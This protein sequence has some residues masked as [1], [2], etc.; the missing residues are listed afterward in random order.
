MKNRN[1]KEPI[2]RKS[3]YATDKFRQKLACEERLKELL[4]TYNG[5]FPDLE[6]MNNPKKWDFRAINASRMISD[7]LD[8]RN[9]ARIAAIAKLVDCSKKTLDF[10]VGPGDILAYLINQKY[11]IDYTG[12]D[13]AK[14][15]IDRLT[16]IFPNQ[17]FFC[18]EIKEIE[19]SSFQQIFALE[20][21]EHIEIPSIK[22]I[23]QHIW[24][25]LKD[26]GTLI[27]SVPIYEKLEDFTLCCSKCGH[28]ENSAGHVRAFIPQLV[29]AELEFAGFKIKEYKL[30]F[31]PSENRI[32]N[33]IKTALRPILHDKP[34]TL[35]VKAEKDS[36]ATNLFPAY[37]KSG[38]SS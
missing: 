5:S 32:R 24:R 2:E 16:K 33:I 15:F 20:V 23:Y 31:L 30:V 17:F 12:I 37:I 10:G 3:V 13:I 27:I 21:F 28:L 36:S 9:S 4:Q 38:N 25:I 26:K 35:V 6:S 18:R 19:D 34:V 8:V 11:Y 14:N 29:F 1:E 22:S 7:K